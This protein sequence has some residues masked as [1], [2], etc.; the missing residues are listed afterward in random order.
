LLL[1]FPAVDVSGD[2]RRA[3]PPG[4]VGL[5]TLLPEEPVE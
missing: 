4:V 3:I 2:V 5:F 1:D